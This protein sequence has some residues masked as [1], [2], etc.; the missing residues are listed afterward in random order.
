MRT[1]FY[2]LISLSLL[3]AVGCSRGVDRRLVLA[4]TLMWTATD[5]TLSILNA[6]NS[7]LQPYKYSAKELDRENGLDLYDSQARWFDPMLPGTTTQDPLAEKYFSISPYTWCAGNPVVFIDEKGD[8]VAVLNLGGL[9]GHSA[10]LIQNKKGEWAYF[11]MNGDYFYNYSLGLGLVGGKPYHDLGKKAFKS[12]KAFLESKYNSTGTESQILN[13]YVNNYGFKEA[14]ILPTTPNQDRKIENKFKEEA[15]KSYNLA[16]RQCAQV[17]QKSLNAGG[18]KTTQK[19]FIFLI[20]KPALA[21]TR[22]WHHILLHQH[23]TLY[24]IIIHK[25]NTLN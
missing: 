10:L 15:K 3:A 23:L 24:D 21:V 4:D 19:E 9:I 14:Y 20:A 11:S 13:D 7:Q 1:C 6:S 25:E 22:N 18:I 12:P 8:S 5:S 16:I 17:A 2:I